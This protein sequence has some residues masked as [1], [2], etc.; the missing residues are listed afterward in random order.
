MSYER[1]I[2]LM[3]AVFLTFEYAGDRLA[4]VLDTYA[5]FVGRDQG[6]VSCTWMND[7]PIVGGFCMFESVDAAER[8]L[9]SPRM[10]AL[11]AHPDVSD[12]YIQHFSTL[13][14]ISSALP[15]NTAMLHR[16]G[17][18]QGE[19]CT[20]WQGGHDHRVIDQIVDQPA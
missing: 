9:D 7:G 11:A 19:A 5:T 6:M 18:G 20:V 12:F 2:C 17:S 13:S 14:A 15:S 10:R 1:K 16:T 4:E 3:H 8:F